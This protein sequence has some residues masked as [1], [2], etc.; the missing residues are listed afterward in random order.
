MVNEWIGWISIGMMALSGFAG[1]ATGHAV[2]R[3]RIKGLVEDRDYLMKGGNP[4]GTPVYMSRVDC[5]AFQ[6]RYQASHCTEIAKIQEELAEQNMMLQ[7][8]RNYAFYRMT[9]DGLPL[10]RINQIL[11]E[12][13]WRAEGWGKS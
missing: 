2:D 9:A 8:I 5:L 13:H 4:H 11:G 6:D 7:A 1:I 10:E 3:V 12:K